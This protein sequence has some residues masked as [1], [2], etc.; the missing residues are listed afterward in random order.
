MPKKRP[1][2][3]D[4]AAATVATESIDEDVNFEDALYRLADAVR[5]LEQ[6]NL[7]LDESLAQYEQG[8]RYLSQCQKVLETAERKIEILSGFDADGNPVTQDFDDGEEMSLEE[9][10]D[11]RSRRR[12][13]ERPP[14]G[15]SRR[16]TEP[17]TPNQKRTAKRKIRKT[18]TSNTA[19][20]STAVPASDIPHNSLAQGEASNANDSGNA[21]EGANNLDVDENGTLF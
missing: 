15:K 12:S 20:E 6:G 5:Q 11:E 13:A 2:K 1:K 7:S 19:A 17:T 9:K 10:A 14:T 4:V 18:A 3:E 16:A 8:I 21:P